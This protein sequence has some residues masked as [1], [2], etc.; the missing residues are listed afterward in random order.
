MIPISDDNPTLRRP[1]V[2]I[3]LL[4]ALGLV[5]LFIQGAGFDQ[6]AL[7]ASVCNY[8]LVPG[9]LTGLARLGGGVPIGPNMLCVVDDYP[10][11]FATPVTSMFLH[12]GWAHILGNAL[13]LW[14]FGNNVEDAMG[15]MRFVVFYLL[16]GLA[17]AALQIAVSPASPV[18][19]VGASGAISGVLGAYLVLFPR[20]RV[21]VLFIWFIFVQIISV[22]AFLMLL[23]WIGYQVLAGLPSLLSSQQSVSGGVAFWAHIGGFIAGVLLIKLF[24][25]PKLTRRMREHTRA[26]YQR[27]G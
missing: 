14:V 15:R 10:I 8:G 25:D 2:T 6:I 21:K 12:G 19:M 22:P 26:R 16:C 23:W 4:A 11:N 27:W 9:E 20:V 1:V 13:F 3:A 17:A 18:P 5:W 24:E 7:A